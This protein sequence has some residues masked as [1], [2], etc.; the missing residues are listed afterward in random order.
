[1]HQLQGLQ[2]DTFFGMTVTVLELRRLMYDCMLLMELDLAEVMTIFSCLCIML[3]E[4]CFVS[5]LHEFFFHSCV[6][7]YVV[8]SYIFQWLRT[9]HISRIK[10]ACLGSNSVLMC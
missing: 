3:R 2:V 9:C 5:Q 1:M 7:F 4:L 8:I 10:Y 6:K